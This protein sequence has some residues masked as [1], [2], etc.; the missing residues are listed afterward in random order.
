MNGVEHETN[1]ISDL[2]ILLDAKS[3][4]RFGSVCYSF[5][6]KHHRVTAMVQNRL[7]KACVILF[8]GLLWVQLSG[9]SCLYD[10][11][12]GESLSTE[13]TIY[14]SVADNINGL[15]QSTEDN[16]P[17][18]LTFAS[19][20]SV[21]ASARGPIHSIAVIPPPLSRPL[22]S[23]FLFHPPKVLQFPLVA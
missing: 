22:L 21:P 16:C 15:N 19:V 8:L 14:R 2:Q 1:A 10:F 7:G 3:L 6:T 9:L 23:S 18:H 20:M 17:C 5:P 12:Q 13:P 4:T 11:S